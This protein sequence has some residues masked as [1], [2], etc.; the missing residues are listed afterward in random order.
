MRTTAKGV[1]KESM[2]VG[3]G[4]KEELVEIFS[5]PVLETLVLLYTKLSFSARIYSFFSLF[6]GGVRVKR[7]GGTTFL[8]SLRS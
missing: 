3:E 1:K 5:F 4:N 8:F 2:I 7:N 6:K